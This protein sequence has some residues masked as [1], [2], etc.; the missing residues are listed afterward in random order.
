MD[1]FYSYFFVSTNKMQY[2]TSIY[3]VQMIN[4]GERNF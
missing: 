4:I 3:I 2:Q 1:T